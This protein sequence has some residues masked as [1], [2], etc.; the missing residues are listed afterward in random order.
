MITSFLF[1]TF[2]KYAIVRTL[3]V[4]LSV[5]LLLFRE[6][7]DLDLLWF[8]R[9]SLNQGRNFFRTGPG[10]RGR[11]LKFKFHTSSYKNRISLVFKKVMSL[12]LDRGEG[13]ESKVDGAKSG[14]WS[15]RRWSSVLSPWCFFTLITD[16]LGV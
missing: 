1:S 9:K 6:L 4:R 3:S 10:L 5:P 7:A 11:G 8:N 15:P 12:M 2:E 16:L 14:R 13:G